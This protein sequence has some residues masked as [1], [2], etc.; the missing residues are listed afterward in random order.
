[1]TPSFKHFILAGLIL[2]NVSLLA[3][4]ATIPDPPPQLEKVAD[5]V[6][7]PFSGAYLKLEVW[8]DNVIRVVS[9]KDR[10]F[11]AHRSPATE[12]RQKVKTN[13]KLSTDLSSTHSWSSPP[14]TS[15][16]RGRS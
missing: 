15:A 14:F 2:A 1:M 9:A 7:F 10:A 11:I 3:Q 8:A 5:G 13:W 6:I 16:G 12:V 4:P